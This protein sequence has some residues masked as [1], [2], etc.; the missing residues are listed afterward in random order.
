MGAVFL[1][2][3][4]A[5]DCVDHKIL[6]QKLTCSVWCSRRCSLVDECRI[7]CMADHSKSHVQGTAE[8]QLA[9]AVYLVK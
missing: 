2:L 1:D 7:F 8:K 3:T 6:L 9:D 5:F 4:K